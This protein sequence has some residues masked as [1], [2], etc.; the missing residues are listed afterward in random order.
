MA[1]TDEH[2]WTLREAGE[3]NLGLSCTNEGLAIGRTQLVERS[4]RGFAVRPQKDL[5]RI[6]GRGFVSSLRST[7]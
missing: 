1:A 5:E 3:N 4:D 2:L 7:K 6:L